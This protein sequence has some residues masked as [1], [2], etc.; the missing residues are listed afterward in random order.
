MKCKNPSNYASKPHYFEAHPSL[1]E[2]KTALI[3]CIF[4]EVRVLYYNTVSYHASLRKA[5][6]SDLFLV[7]LPATQDKKSYLEK[8]SK[9]EMTAVFDGCCVEQRSEGLFTNYFERDLLESFTTH[10]F[11]PINLEGVPYLWIGEYLTEATEKNDWDSPRLMYMGLGQVLENRFPS[12]DP[13][14]MLWQPINS[15]ITSKGFKSILSTLL[16]APTTS[17]TNPSL[18]N[19]FKRHPWLPWIDIRTIL[20]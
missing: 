19:F 5:S 9:F 16:F 2:Q 4:L 17:W 12:V 10:Q 14:V 3:R 20:F 15:S 1:A 7:P 18:V 6:K 11:W 8:S 13:R